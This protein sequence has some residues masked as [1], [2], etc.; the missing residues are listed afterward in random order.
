MGKTYEEINEKIRRKQAVVVTAEEIIDIV[1]EKGSAEAA[2]QVDVVTTGTFGPMCS[3]GILFNVGHTKPKMKIEKAW[4][5]N[6]EAY[7]GIAAVDC[8]LGATQLPDDDPRNKVF[9]GS[10]RYGGGHVIED[11]VSGKDLTFKATAY[12]TDCYPRKKLETLIRLEDLNDAW[13]LNP[14]NSYQNYNV[15]VNRSGS[16]PI[17]TYMGTLRPKIANANYC[18]AGQLSP[19]LCDPLYKT[20]GVGTRIFLAGGVGYVIYNGTQHSPDET[21]S[22]NS[23]PRGGAGTLALIGDLKKASTEFL[24]GVSLTGYGVSLAVGLG[25]PIPVL[26]EDVVKYAAVRDSE[27]FAPV[28]DYSDDYPNSE[29]EPIAYVS[30]AELRSGCVTIEGRQ[31][32]TA[33]LSS[34]PKAR[35][36]AAQLKE[37][38]EAGEFEL[39]KPAQLLPSV[40][41]GIKFRPLKYRPVEL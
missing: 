34:Y 31:V 37:W 1:D 8:Y 26:N 29:G 17:Y 4:L 28:V 7:S 24:R 20:I 36:I 41:S 3:S 6:V 19:L 40:E 5:N 13:L 27:I 23:I 12:G 33:S 2:K 30:Y 32:E 14:R 16:R 22:K 39:S 11:L 9:P 35:E 15:A 18:S 21:R 10:F 38:I 25:V